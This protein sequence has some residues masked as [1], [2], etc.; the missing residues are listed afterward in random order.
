MKTIPI[1]LAPQY[2]SG[3]STLAFCLRIER[4]DGTVIAVTSL[5]KDLVVNG[6]TYTAAHGLDVSALVYQVGLA[7]NNAELTVIPDDD[8]ADVTQQDLLTGLYDG[9]EF[10]LFQVNYLDT[11]D[12]RNTLLRGL[13]GEVPKIDRG[14]YTVEMRAWSQLLQQAIGIVTSKTCRARFGS[15]GSDRRPRCGIDASL[16][17]VTGTIT[18]ATSRQIV[19]DSA[20]TE[21]DDWFAEGIFTP[22]SGANVGYSR[23]IRSYESDTFTF[24]LAFP[25]AFAPGDTYSAVAGCRK[26]LEDCRDKY[27]NVLNFQGEPH[28]R[29]ID[30]ITASPRT[31]V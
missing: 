1:A 29:G 4:G 26:R 5:D 9:A 25:Y 11:T 10:E 12:G 31:D 18:T 6:E 24:D 17:T 2:T 22:N 16:F 14:Q 19:V 7:V 27:D 21:A 8:E 28:G 20:R 15:D 30:V 23:R 3:S 13:L